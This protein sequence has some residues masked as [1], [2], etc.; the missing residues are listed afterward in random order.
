[1]S[2]YF[3]VIAVLI[4]FVGGAILL[5]A[6]HWSYG[7]IKKYSEIVTMLT[8]I[9]VGMQL[10][11]RPSEGL[12]LFNLAGNLRIIMKLDGLGCIFAGLI[13]FLWPLA[14]LYAFEYMKHDKDRK[15]VFFG[16]YIITYGA[17]LGIAFA[18]NILTM[19]FFYEMM[20]LVTVYLVLHPMTK[21]AIRASRQYLYYSLGGA[22]FA[23]FSIV[24]LEI[25]GDTSNFVLGGVLDLEM[26]KGN[27]NLVLFMFVLAFCGFGVK[28]ALFPFHGWL[29]KASVAPTPVTAL[30]HA[31]AVV[32]AG[33][34]A[35]IR[36]IYYSYGI[37]FLKGTWA[38]YVVMLLAMITILYGST[39]AVKEIHLKRRLAYSTVSNLS[40]ILLGATFMN[41]AGMIGSM[42]HLVMHAFMKICGFFCI[43]AIMHQTGK[44]YMNEIEGLAKKMPVI[45]GCLTLAGIS[46][47]GIPPFAG[48]ISKWN[49]AAG[50]FSMESPMGILAVCVLLY[51]S[52]LT[53][54]YM[55]QYVVRAWFP[56]KEVQLPDNSK[57]ADPNWYMKLPI[58]IFAIMILIL[59]MFSE[60]LVSLIREVAYGIF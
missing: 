36:I 58:I 25:F 33:A 27:V 42:V 52:L 2:S 39:M 7:R 29:P 13:A 38:Q 23:F 22:A 40:Y 55:G 10:L 53:V 50:G 45:F 24:C 46:L 37:E 56:R 57:A 60:N 1:M 11:N 4:P 20:T 19:Y 48:F 47:A 8:S 34:F 26:A 41:P 51:S 43:G 6:K 30:L 16:F 3:L 54:I 12:V 44:N 14:N 32:K 49:L 31:V 28:A 21:K 35:I 18:G 17:T 9:L 15:H 5:G 59:G